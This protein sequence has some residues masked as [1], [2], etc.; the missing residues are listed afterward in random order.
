MHLKLIKTAQL[1]LEPWSIGSG[2][3]VSPGAPVNNCRRASIQWTWGQGAQN[4]NST[5]LKRTRV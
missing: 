4:F 5:E 1:K 2:Y 3:R